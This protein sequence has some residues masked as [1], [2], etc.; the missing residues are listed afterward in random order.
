M[1]TE[2]IHRQ[3]FEWLYSQ[4][5]HDEYACF[6]SLCLDLHRMIFVIPSKHVTMD[7]N[8]V[9]DA[10]DMRSNFIE[11]L[12]EQGVHVPIG[13]K[14]FDPIKPTVFEVLVALARRI[15]SDIMYDAEKENRTYKWFWLMISNLGILCPDD[16]KD[17]VNTWMCRKFDPDGTGSL[18]PLQNPSIDQTRLDIW[19]QMTNYF[20]E[21]GDSF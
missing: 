16:R 6:R 2:E 4:V 1:K 15:E 20:S 10:Y 7:I 21:R 14:L 18:F 5:E 9:V 8:R 3:Y 11:S 12:A 13:G 17:I 19:S